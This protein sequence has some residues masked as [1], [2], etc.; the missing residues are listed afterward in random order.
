MAQQA[1]EYDVALTDDLNEARK[2]LEIGYD[3]VFMRDR[4]IVVRRIVTPEG[5]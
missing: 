2:L 5:L 3:Y 4:T 1:K